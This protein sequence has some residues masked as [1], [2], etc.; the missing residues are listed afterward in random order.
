MKKF[1]YL[2]GFRK[3]KPTYVNNQLFCNFK[4]NIPVI[5]YLHPFPLD[6]I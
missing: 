1:Q 6:L 3:F 2:Y 4:D 5:G